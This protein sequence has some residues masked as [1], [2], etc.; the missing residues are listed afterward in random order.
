M[1]TRRT[2]FV[3]L[4]FVILG[5]CVV[6]SVSLGAKTIGIKSVLAAF[7]LGNGPSFEVSVVQA[8][9]PRTIFGILAGAALAISG[10]LMQSL[11]RNPIADPSILGVNTGAS[12]FVVMGIAFLNIGSKWQYIWLA[13]AGAAITALFVYG[14][15]SMGGGGATPIKLALSGAAASIALQSLVNVIMLPKNNVMD[16]FRFWQTGS[17][18]G[19]TWQDIAY[20]GPFLAIGFIFALVLSSSLNTLALGD[21]VAT[22]LGINVV[23]IRG[24]AA[25]AGV[26]LFATTTALAGPIAFVGL[27]IP[28]LMRILFGP[29]MRWILPMSAVGGASLLLI[30]DVIGR[31]LGGAGEVEVG[32]IT[33]VIGAPVFIFI[34]RKAKVKSL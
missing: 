1:K 31:I 4:L 10:G 15:A 14:L 16:T 29:D 12:L 30:A 34:V 2:L 8:R 26:L 33:A 20:L 32:I 7:G 28:H 24:L 21:D 5:L 11:T 22:G 3:I 27:M 9:F 17:I 23:L 6:A 18:G 25:L 13:F 19:A